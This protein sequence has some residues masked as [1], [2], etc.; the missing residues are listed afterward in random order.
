[1]EPVIEPEVIF[2]TPTV[3]LKVPIAKVPPATVTAPVSTRRLE[4]PS[5]SVPALTVV[6]PV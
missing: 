4:A 1:M 5:V 6:P 2:T 3:S